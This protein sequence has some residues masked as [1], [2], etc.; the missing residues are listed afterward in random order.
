MASASDPPAHPALQSA[1][2]LI[3]PPQ[4]P[5]AAVE[6]SIGPPHYPAEGTQSDAFVQPSL[7]ARK[8]HANSDSFRRGI[9]GARPPPPQTHRKSPHG[10]DLTSRSNGISERPSCPSCPAI[11]RP[12]HPTAS[13]ATRGGRN[14]HRPTPLPRRGHPVRRVRSTE[15]ARPQGARKL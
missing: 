5:P 14:L 11:C 15:P 6:T 7:R 3:L 13:T 2:R 10:S 4:Q 9:V 1:D 12:A 8:G